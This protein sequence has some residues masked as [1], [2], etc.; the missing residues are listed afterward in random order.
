MD[1]R[2]PITRSPRSVLRDFRGVL[3]GTPE[4][5]GAPE[6][7]MDPL[8]L[9]RVRAVVTDDLERSDIVAVLAPTGRDGSLA[10]RV[11]GRWSIQVKSYENMS[12]LSD[13]VRAGVGAVILA[14]ECLL[15]EARDQLLEALDTQPTWSDVPLIILMAEG[16]LSRAIAEGVEE[17]AS[18]GNVT[19][20][21]RPVRVATLV[22]VVRSAL[23]A[24]ERQYDVH[25]HMQ[26]LTAARAEAEAANRAKVEFLAMMSHELRTPLNAIGGYAELLEMGVR[27]PVN[28]A[29]RSDLG[30]IQKSQRHLLGL[31]NG[32]LNYARIETGTV[33]YEISNVA[34]DELLATAES[35]VAPQAQARGLRL[36]FP[37]CSSTVVARADR[38]KTQQVVL[39][40]LTNAVKFTEPGGRVRLMCASTDHTVIVRV[41]DT[42]RGIPP[43]KIEAI[44]EPFIQVDSQLTRTQDG[45][46]LGLSISRDLARGMG[47]D[48]VAQS[49]V[50][51]GSTF[52]LTLPGPE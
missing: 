34:M 4:Y 29:Q 45:V 11:L 22:T 15:A 49:R 12:A 51:A 19:L 37:G 28:D 50:G 36:E 38:E 23:R 41:E 40:L 33:P 6:P 1:D 10:E 26:S 5:T 7:L 9:C 32:V 46:G 3:T 17:I 27:G 43:E 44:F 39:N 21:E 47:G 18:R 52:T 14:E 30:K 24:R 31:I 16:E 25:D 20:L 48:L 35:L 8:S 2:K 13:A 42:G